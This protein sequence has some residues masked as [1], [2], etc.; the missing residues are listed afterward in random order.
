MAYGAAAGDLGGLGEV[1][2]VTLEHQHPCIPRTFTLALS[3]TAVD[4]QQL[5]GSV[6]VVLVAGVHR[7]AISMPSAL[8]YCRHMHT[9][10]YYAPGH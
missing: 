8:F 2:D 9:D 4:Q 6:S 10:V 3:L 5:N 1:E 7:H